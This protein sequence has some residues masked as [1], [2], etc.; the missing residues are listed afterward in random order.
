MDNNLYE[1]MNWPDIEEIVYS[2]SSHPK[3]LLG[4]H[5]CKY[6]YLIQVFRPDAVSVTISVEGKK[7]KY[8]MEKVD[9]AGFFAVIIPGKKKVSYTV[10]VESVQG[11]V[12]SFADPYSFDNITTPKDYKLFNAGSETNALNIMGNKVMTVNGVDGTLFTVWAPNALRVSVTG[13][14]NNWDGRVHQMEKIGESGVFELFIPGITAGAEY[15]YEVKNRASGITQKL[16]PYCTETTNYINC[17]SIV[18]DEQEYRWEDALWMTS[19]AK[20]RNDS[21]PLS[22]LEVNLAA[23]NSIVSGQASYKKISAAILDYV[24]KTGYTHVEFMPVAEFMGDKAYGYASVS[25]FSPTSRYGTVKEFKDM[26]NMFHKEGIGVII[27]WNASYFGCDSK[28]ISNFDGENCYGYLKPRLEKK[29]GWNVTTF[30]YETGAVRSFLLSNVNM[31]LEE[32]HVDGVRIDGVASMLYLD[33]GKQPGQWQPNMYGD[34]ENLEAVMFIKSVNKLIHD[35]N[36]GA[37]SIAEETSGWNNVTE[38]NGGDNL[39]F[40]YK[41]NNYFKDDVIS[42]MDTDPLFRK[43]KY[44]KLTDGMLYTYRENFILSFSHDDFSI[45]KK[46]VYE[47]ASGSSD[48]DKLK[49]IRAVLGYIFTHPGAKMLSMGQDIGI[50]SVWS[51]DMKSQWKQLEEEK[52]VEMMRYLKDINDLYR[53]NTAMYELDSYT[54]GFEWLEN[55]NSEET[56]I[57]YVRRDSK[58]NEITVVVN[59]TP[60]ERKD[61]KLKVSKPGK[62]KILLN[63]D[64]VKYGGDSRVDTKC[65]PSMYEL[66]ED[67]KDILNITIPGSSAVIYGYTPFSQ[68][69]IKEIEIRRTAAIAKKEAEDK[70]REARELA[71]KADEEAKAAIEAERVAKESCRLAVKASKE[72]EKRAKEAM[73]AS[74]RIDEETKRK[75][76]EL[77]KNHE[78]TE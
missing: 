71:I 32:Y 38:A 75:L 69:E 56:V 47:I 50:N 73:E 6:G 35:R 55:S 62:Y 53:N 28:G 23:W 13:D 43:G 61:Y 68:E 9:E 66:N 12:T 42:F 65:I 11:K 54:E 20:K 18:S 22:V 19:R 21:K 14:F 60:V 15:M 30:A 74:L 17:N 58:G 33:Y 76:D 72:A 44:N 5:I 77:K 3:E 1:L 7:K 16:D 25:Y 36:D 4:G 27:D 48:K 46:S 52:Y 67:N 49:D 63:S 31:W 64:D 39:G 78:R 34:N 41:W 70:A 57:G 29:P 26:I 45:D 10:N 37:V 40:D 2:E 24:K 59:F 8:P 51:T